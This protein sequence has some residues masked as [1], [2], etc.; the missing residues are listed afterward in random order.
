MNAY[1]IVH[2]KNEV[3]FGL[4]EQNIQG[5]QSRLGQ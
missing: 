4:K 3:Y 1:I 5:L 2:V